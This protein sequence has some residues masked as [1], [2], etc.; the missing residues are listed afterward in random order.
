MPDDPLS[1]WLAGLRN[2]TWHMTKSLM[3]GF[4]I[5]P[6]QPTAA[7]TCRIIGHAF[8]H[9]ELSRTKS[10]IDSLEIIGDCLYFIGVDLTYPR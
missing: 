2:E 7:A 9:F 5:A 10:R 4:R 1:A 8:R 6:T 3:L